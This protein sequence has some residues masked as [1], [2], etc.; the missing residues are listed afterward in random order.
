MCPP[1]QG[2]RTFTAGR[3][4]ACC[5]RHCSGSASLAPACCTSGLWDFARQLTTFRA[6]GPAPAAGLLTF[7][8]L[9]R[10][11][12]GRS[13]AGAW[14]R[15]VPV[16][17]E[18]MKSRELAQTHARTGFHS[19]GRGALAARPMS[20]AR[21]AVRVV[22]AATSLPT[23][24]TNANSRAAFRATSSGLD[25]LPVPGP[26]G[27]ARGQQPWTS[28]A[29]RLQDKPAV[30]PA[31]TEMWLDFTADLGDG[32]DSTYTVASLLAQNTLRWTGMSFPAAGCWCSA[33]TR[34]T[35][36]R[37]RPRTRTGWR[38]RTGRPAAAGPPAPQAPRRASGPTASVML[39]L[40]GNHDWYDGLTSFIRL[41][42]RQRNIGGWRTI[43]TRS[44]FACGSGLTRPATDAPGW[45]LWAW[46]A[47]WASTSTSRNWTTSTER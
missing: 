28:L 17:V 39:A 35:R 44:Y 4:T 23:S 41:F 26:A 29:C 21:T 31:A 8:R 42:T 15:P 7:G 10:A 14:T 47:N 19:P 30:A 36:W 3:R 1:T 9:F 12:S 18:A 27:A 11:S 45:W 2:R 34:C 20:L 46:T 25:K 43:Q 16:H 22:L 33:A 6:E 32:F 13:T 24:A 37:P 38:A 40:P 5:K